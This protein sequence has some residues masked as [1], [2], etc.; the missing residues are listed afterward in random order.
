MKKK[1][2]VDERSIM[3]SN[4]YSHMVPSDWAT[5]LVEMKDQMTNAELTVRKLKRTMDA[6]CATSK[7]GVK[8]HTALNHE[9][10]N[11]CLPCNC[12]FMS[13][14]PSGNAD[15]TSFVSALADVGTEVAAVMKQWTELANCEEDLLTDQMQLI[16]DLMKG[17]KDFFERQSK[18]ATQ[19]QKAFEKAITAS[20]SKT[21]PKDS[22]ALEQ[23]MATLKD[24]ENRVKFSLY[25][26]EQ[27]LIFLEQELSFHLARFLCE[28]SGVEKQS[29]HKVKCRQPERQLR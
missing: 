6:F 1:F 21:E 5:R 29:A 23:K 25:C 13:F 10:S 20:R 2:T 16:K 22:A 12:P 17:W 26:V 9:L 18:Y 11:L 27:E 7:E 3:P 28:L 14:S 8:N 4:L 15:R 19:D 24:A